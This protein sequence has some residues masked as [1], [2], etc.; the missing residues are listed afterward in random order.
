MKKKRL[1]PDLIAEIFEARS[2][3]REAEI[4]AEVDETVTRILRKIAKGKVRLESGTSWFSVHL[5]YWRYF[6]D[7]PYLIFSRVEKR[8]NDLRIGIKITS[9]RH[10]DILPFVVVVNINYDEMYRD[11]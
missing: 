9:I 2:Q 1:D 11:E 6:L 4:Q 3:Q 10:H 5:F 7:L 8:I